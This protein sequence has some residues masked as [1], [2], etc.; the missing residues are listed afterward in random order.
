MFKLSLGLCSGEELAQDPGPQNYRVVILSFKACV[1]FPS[2]LSLSHG[3]YPL[4]P[5]ISPCRSAEEYRGCLG[6]WLATSVG[7]NKASSA[8]VQSLSSWKAYLATP[9][10]QLIP[11]V[12]L[13]RELQHLHC[14]TED[15]DVREVKRH[16]QDH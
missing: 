16:A 6:S 7:K 12:G 11:A 1:H 13:P 2:H 4:A 3:N 15:E 8:W 10:S 9:N 5:I 14:A